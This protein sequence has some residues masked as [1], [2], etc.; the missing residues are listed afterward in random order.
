MEALHRRFNSCQYQTERTDVWRWP[1]RC[2]LTF[3]AQNVV[4]S[5]PRNWSSVHKVKLCLV[6]RSYDVSRASASNDSVD[7]SYLHHSQALGMI[8]GLYSP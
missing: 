5:K 8:A 2:V 1:R 4:Y 7:A 3:W 6:N